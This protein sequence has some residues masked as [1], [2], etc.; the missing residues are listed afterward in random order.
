MERTMEILQTRKLWPRERDSVVG[1]IP[2]I[3]PS[4]RPCIWQIFIE[5]VLGWEIR[6]EL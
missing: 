1:G 2:F 5:P 3:Y 6:L 4:I